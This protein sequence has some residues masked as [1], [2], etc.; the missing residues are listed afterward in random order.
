MT[1]HCLALV[2]KSTNLFIYNDDLCSNERYFLC[3]ER[4]IPERKDELPAIEHKS[5]NHLLLSGNVSEAPKV[6]MD[7]YD[8]GTDE[9]I[10]PDWWPH[11]VQP[12]QIIIR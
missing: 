1:E 12:A 9:L 4:V 3:E 5:E 8:E 11:K 7:E 10:V 6:T 2:R